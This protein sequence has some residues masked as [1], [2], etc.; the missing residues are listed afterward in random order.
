MEGEYWRLVTPIFMHSGFTHACLIAFH[1]FLFGPALE[2]LLGKG[3]FLFV[4]LVSG[5]LANVATLT[6]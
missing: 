2:R 6:A 4:Y 3:R 1:L 5:I